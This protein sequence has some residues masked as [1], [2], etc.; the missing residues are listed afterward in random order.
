MR[1]KSR[2]KLF[3]KNQK[4]FYFEE[5]LQTNEPFKKQKKTV[6]SE[7]RIYILFFLFISLILIFS[8]SI[9]NISLQKSEIKKIENKK[10]SIISLRKDIIDRNGILISRNITAYHAA[11]KTSLVKDKKKF[12]VKVKLVLPEIST[13][14]LRKDLNDEK[15]FYLKKRLSNDQKSKLWSLGE[16]GIIFEPFQAR[17]YPHSDLYSHVVGQIDY[18]NYGISGVEKYY[19]FFLKDIN[20][21]KPLQLS[22]DTNVQFVI[23]TELENSLDVFK[24]KGGA[25]LLMD[26][27]NGEIISLIS[28]PDFD[29]NK[30]DNIHNK[31]FMNKIT[32]G[33]FELGSIFKTFTIAL[34]IEK[35]LVDS[36][37]I[38]KDISQ[39]IKCSVHEISDIKKFP[40]EMTVQDILVQSSNIGTI[41]I[42]RLIGQERLK[43]FLKDINILA[44]P[45]LELDE[46]GRPIQFEWTKC[47]LE[48]VSFGHGITTTPLQAATAYASLIN[49]GKLITPTLEKGKN[50]NFKPNRII[51]KNTSSEIRKILRKVVTDEKGTAHLADIYGYNVA[52]KTGTSQYYENKKKNINTFISFFSVYEKKYVFLLML[53]DPKI[54]D[55]LIYDYRGLKIKGHRN[56]AGWNVVY[57]AG[58][59]IEKI[60]P[61]LAINNGEI[62]NQ[63]VVKK[64]N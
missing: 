47:K 58:K 38:I 50:K 52:G 45:N 59:I 16:K 49:G 27:D 18:D 12:L 15:Y 28:L 54:A 1:K 55:Q 23:K 35:D 31:K 2:K 17:V 44:Y 39:K 46:L 19:D 8:I 6:M 43:S 53:D 48:T 61:I 37:T 20:N 7:D 32:K 11:V 10:K 5:Y 26:A 56:E 25:S 57:S 4:S 41:K 3:N 42:A 62:H 14:K 63:H 33:V 34:A 36:K 13:Q 21:N 24:A 9:T 30:R 29:I 60:G 64:S 51:S 22:L 40:K